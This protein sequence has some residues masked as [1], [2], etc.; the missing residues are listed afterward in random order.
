VAS[1]TAVEKHVASTFNT[2][3]LGATATEHGRVLAVLTCV[4]ESTS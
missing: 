4:R 2:L 3:G 1:E